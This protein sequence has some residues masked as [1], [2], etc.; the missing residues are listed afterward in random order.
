[1]LHTPPLGLNFVL[2]FLSINAE[3]KV[4]QYHKSIYQIKM[5]TTGA[6]H[7]RPPRSSSVDY[8][9]PTGP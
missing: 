8:N 6:Y 5:E 7:M 3:M 2:K 4:P 1:M 9:Y